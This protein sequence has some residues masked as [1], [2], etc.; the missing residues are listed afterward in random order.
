MGSF[1]SLLRGAARIWR[2]AAVVRRSLQA[3]VRPIEQIPSPEI[4]PDVDDPLPA[5]ISHP[6]FQKTIAWFSLDPTLGRSL[7]SPHAQVLLFS[8][9]RSLR[10]EHVFE[11]GT[12]RAGTSEAIAR[13]LHAHGAG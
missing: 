8:L 2:G 7:L 11:I 10:P 5:V 12:F 13:A 4:E 9:A 6:T 1:R 3:K